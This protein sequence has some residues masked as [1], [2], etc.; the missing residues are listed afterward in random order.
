MQHGKSKSSPTARG[1][2]VS[3]STLS[4]LALGGVAL[5]AVS[6]APARPLAQS[7]YAGGGGVT[8][9]DSLPFTIDACGRYVIGSCLTG[10]A[11]Q[12]GITISASVSDVTINLGGFTLAGV[13]GSL[14]GIR[15][16]SLSTNIVIRNGTL[17]D[18]GG[19]GVDVEAA[20]NT[21]IRKTRWWM[22][23][24]RRTRLRPPHPQLC[25]ARRLRLRWRMRP[26]ARNR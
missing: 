14:D 11:G 13:P 15:A 23:I 26:R 1:P 25:R 10:V 5:V 2:L 22:R 20:S 24:R 8:R 9:I 17:R 21:R 3:R 18:W 7:L 19:D 12:N 6:V 4:L 16:T